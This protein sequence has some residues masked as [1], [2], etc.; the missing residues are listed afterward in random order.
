[1]KSLSPM[2]ENIPRFR[3]S[4]RKVVNINFLTL[5]GANSLF[6]PHIYVHKFN[7]NKKKK[8]RTQQN[9]SAIWTLSK[10]DNFL[11]QKMATTL[12]SFLPI[13]NSHQRLQYKKQTRKQ[14][15]N[16]EYKFKLGKK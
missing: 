9:L 7:N 2:W 11:N 3:S 5:I 10:S 4:H 13:I 16:L 6:Q 8:K 1:M 12:Y 14:I 15:T